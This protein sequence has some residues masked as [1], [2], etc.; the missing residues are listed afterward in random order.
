MTLTQNKSRTQYFRA[1]VGAVVINGKGEALAFE[2]RDV[3]G[4]WQLPQGGMEEGEEPI[5]AIMREIFEETGIKKEDLILIREHPD[6]LTYEL[7]PE[8]RSEKT[9]R[10]QTQR[11]FLFRYAADESQIK[12]STNGEFVAWE[13]MPLQELIKETVSFRKEVYRRVRAAFTEIR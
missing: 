7:P 9:G 10:G 11:W 13:W 6:Y 1:S 2:R 3:S 12:L 4:A 5:D 8:Y